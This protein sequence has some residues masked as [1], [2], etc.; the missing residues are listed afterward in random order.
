[1][2]LTESIPSEIIGRKYRILTKDQLTFSVYNICKDIFAKWCFPL[3]KPEQVT[4]EEINNF[5]DVLNWDNKTVPMDIIS[6]TGN[7]SY[8]VPYDFYLRGLYRFAEDV[9]HKLGDNM[10]KLFFEKVLGK[11]HGD[12]SN[13]VNKLKIVKSANM[14]EYTF[15]NNTTNYNDANKQAMIDSILSIYS[16]CRNG[17]IILS[18]YKQGVNSGHRTLI[19]FENINNVLNIYYYDPHG[20][21]EF[22]WSSKLNIYETL[23]N[24]FYEMK[25]Y[26]AKYKL[27]DIVVKEHRTMCL[28]GIQTY[29]AGYDIGMCQIFSSLW[30][31]LVVKVMSKAEKNKIQLPDTEKWIYLIEDYLISQFSTKQMYNALLLFISRLFNYYTQENKNYMSEL[32]EYNRYLI[33]TSYNKEFMDKF[34]VPFSRHTPSEED[35]KEINAYVIKLA[36]E[37]IEEARL[38]ELLDVRIKTIAIACIKD[39]RINYNIKLIIEK[40]ITNKKLKIN[41]MVRTVAI[42]EFNEA[43]SSEDREIT[44]NRA[45]RIAIE[46]IRS[47]KIKDEY[48]KIAIE[49]IKNSKVYVQYIL[50]NI[51]PNVSITTIGK[52]RLEDYSKER[53]Q[54]SEEYEKQIKKQKQEEEKYSKTLRARIPFFES[55]KL[56]DE[57]KNDS[58]CLTGCCSYDEALKMKLCNVSEA[59]PK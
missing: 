5:L 33:T 47:L 6:Y 16:K 48:K 38:D 2:G 54:E 19:F 21:S 22:S 26:M 45:K 29:A 7:K 46:L 44:E 57:C 12:T 40:E 41:D 14:Y 11:I 32:N 36:Q 10:D 56:F 17:A 53:E 25:P 37:S 43:T 31:Y 35:V 8:N 50:Y 34:E 52:R 4:Q 28:L 24:F 39:S 58:D 13:C 9:E 18:S 49:G 55:K 3:K 42:K 20:S 1:M 30:F 15:F 27:N 51:L 23:S 59:C